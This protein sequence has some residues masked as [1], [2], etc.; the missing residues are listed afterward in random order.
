MRV[1]VTLANEK[2][3]RSALHPNDIGQGHISITAHLSQ[4]AVIPSRLIT[5]VQEFPLAVNLQRIRHCK[6]LT[7]EEGDEETIKEREREDSEEK[8]MKKEKE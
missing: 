4:R 2:S 8:S 7:E 3:T 6:V 5:I 1:L